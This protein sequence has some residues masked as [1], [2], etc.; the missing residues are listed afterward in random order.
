MKA[1]I[2]IKTS[3][4]TAMVL[5]DRKEIRGIRSSIY[6]IVTL[7]VLSSFAL[8][9]FFIQNK[10]LLVNLR[11]ICLLT[12]ILILVFLWI[13]VIRYKLDLYH[14]RQC[15]TLREKLINNL[16]ENDIYNLDLF[17]NAS[18]LIPDIKDTEL[19]WL[20]SIGTIIILIKMFVLLRTIN[21]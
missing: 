12:D 5:E 20:P 18:G 10:V 1:N 8:S 17:P 11:D 16:D 15:L 14:C 4:L 13:F 21:M 3:V 7:L 6:K 2:Q 9:A 19:W